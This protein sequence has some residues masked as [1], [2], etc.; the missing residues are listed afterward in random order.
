MPWELWVAGLSP[1]GHHRAP[2]QPLSELPMSPWGAPEGLSW[3]QR[4]T[5]SVSLV[6]TDSIHQRQH[7]QP[8]LHGKAYSPRLSLSSPSRFLHF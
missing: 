1:P 3:V 7:A 8:C 4:S 2:Q 6:S 5:G